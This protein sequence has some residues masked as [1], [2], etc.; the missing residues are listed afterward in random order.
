M[1]KSW[2]LQR[3]GGQRKE[4]ARRNPRGRRRA[5]R[6]ATVVITRAMDKTRRQAAMESEMELEM[7]TEG[8]GNEEMDG[9]QLPNKS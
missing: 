4:I 9:A 3:I 5:P 8:G 1:R 6:A 7:E 2:L